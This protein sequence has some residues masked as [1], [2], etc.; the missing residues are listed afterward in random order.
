M[1]CT[2]SYDVLLPLLNSLH[3]ILANSSNQTPHFILF[4]H[5]FL[6]QDQLSLTNLP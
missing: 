4:Q 1:P 2:S 6:L 5:H 3:P